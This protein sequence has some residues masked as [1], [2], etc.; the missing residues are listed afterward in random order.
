MK[1][2]GFTFVRN[3]VQFDYPVLESI[4]SVLPLCDEF[5]V[6]VG[7]SSDATRQLIESIHSSKIRILDTQ[8][9]DSLRERGATFA[10]E[11]DKAFRAIAADADWAFYLQADE[12]VHEKDHAAIR[13]AM[14]KYKDDKR[15]D[16]LLFN[17]LHFYGSYDYIGEAYRWYRREVRII[18]NDKAIASYKDAQGFRKKPK[19]KLNV[20][21]VDASIYHYG[22]VRDPRAMQ[23]KQRSFNHY[24]FDDQW[25]E[26]NI[27][28]AETFDYAGIDAL[29]LFEGEHPA[30]MQNRIAAMNWKFQ[31]DISLNRF[32]WKDQ[33]K[34][35]VEKLTGWRVGEF[36]N[37]RIL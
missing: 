31:H 23:G 28:T 16:G 2:S 32:K 22:W 34:R 11:T 8:W 33:L 7:N 14:T 25:I 1:V 9:D 21:P 30:V 37:Y 26:K 20:K 27:G 15:V 6:A 13:Q 10:L 19:T 35:A 18:R 17:Y 29:R 36:R 5:I 4:A 12:V 24:Y 3:A